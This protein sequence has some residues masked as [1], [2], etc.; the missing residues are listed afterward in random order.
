MVGKREIENY[1]KESSQ[2]IL[3]KLSAKIIP[4]DYFMITIIS[5][6]SN[7]LWHDAVWW[8][9]SKVISRCGLDIN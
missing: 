6:L 1:F 2:F 4:V 3:L 5:K 9:W 8:Y 7:F